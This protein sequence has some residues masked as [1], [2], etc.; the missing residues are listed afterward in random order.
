MKTTFIILFSISMFLSVKVSAEVIAGHYR[1]QQATVTIAKAEE[2]W[3]IKCEPSTKEAVPRISLWLTR[4]E[5][6][7][8]MDCHAFHCTPLEKLTRNVYEISIKPEYSTEC[9]LRGEPAIFDGKC[10][11][12][13]SVTWGSARM[14]FDRNRPR[15]EMNERMMRQ[16][17]GFLAEEYGKRR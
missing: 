8:E 5:G 11:G 12:F 9:E 14:C 15:I 13:D 7:Y 6:D 17:C 16:E 3:R 1:G 10:L 2:L 4:F